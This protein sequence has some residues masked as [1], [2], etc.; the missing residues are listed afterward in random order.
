MITYAIYDCFTTTYLIRPVL[1][2]WTFNQLKNINI[3]ELFT[4]FE[5]TPLPIINLSNKKIKNNVNLQKLF[6]KYDDDL[7][8]ISD[9]DE[10]YLNQLTGLVDEQQT[11]NRNPID[12][13][14]TS[15]DSET[16]KYLRQ[17]H[18]HH[19]ETSKRR[20]RR[21]LF[22][23]QQT[24]ELERRFRQ[25]PTETGTHSCLPRWLFADRTP[26]CRESHA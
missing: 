26:R 13:S 23:K 24:F 5:T 18:V 12:S 19:H 25:R 16:S 11:L 22:T 21:V 8:S 2:Q 14:T 17:E 4:S 7:E 6:K 10:I 1:E 9:D 20:K 15:E 3:N